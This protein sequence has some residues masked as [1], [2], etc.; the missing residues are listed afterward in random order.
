MLS[1]FILLSLQLLAITSL[2]VSTDLPIE[3]ISY[4]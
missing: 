2:S 4:K 3:D 1:L